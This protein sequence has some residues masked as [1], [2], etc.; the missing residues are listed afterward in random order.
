ME[1][2]ETEY[3]I[4]YGVRLTRFACSLCAP[5]SCFGL[6]S[7]WRH[8]ADRTGG[9]VISYG[10]HLRAVH[11]F[12]IIQS[13]T[14][15][16]RVQYTRFWIP[17]WKTKRKRAFSYTKKIRYKASG[18]KKEGDAKEPSVFNSD[19]I[20]KRSPSNFYSYMMGNYRIHGGRSKVYI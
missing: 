20:L 11:P 3:W 2:T 7:L 1:K 10:R 4:F 5:P 6:N 14:V 12:F 16:N 18:R 17:H 15:L 13:L 19:P 9:Y 8:R